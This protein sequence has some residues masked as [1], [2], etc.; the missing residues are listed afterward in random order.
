MEFNS[1]IVWK[2]IKA[3]SAHCFLSSGFKK[4]ILETKGLNLR[5]ENILGFDCETYQDEDWP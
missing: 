3:D 4:I 5:Y 2:Y 1:I